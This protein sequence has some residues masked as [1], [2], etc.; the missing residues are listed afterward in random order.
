MSELI[1]HSWAIY[2]GSFDPFTIG[3]M[4]IVGKAFRIF[5]HI[6]IVI[7]TNSGKVRRFSSAKEMETNIR[8]ALEI[9]GIDGSCSVV[10]YDGLIAQYAK[11]NHIKY[12]IRGL[13]NQTDYAYEEN[14]AQINQLI[15]PLEYVY[16][17][18]DRSEIS[19]SMV[20][21]FM[22]HGVDVKQYLPW[23]VY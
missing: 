19:S 20:R 15:A 2:P 22:K 16:F 7:A 5:N 8:H 23:E 18:A 17:R 13:R 21:E 10:I 1:K 6:D 12:V 14:M 11:D 4:D 9:N 3:H